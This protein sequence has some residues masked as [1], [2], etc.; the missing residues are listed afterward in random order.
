MGDLTRRRPLI[1]APLLVGAGLTVG[2][3]VTRSLLVF[4]ILSF[5]VGMFSIASNSLI[6]LAADLAPPERR[7]SAISI[8]FS[9]NLLGIL[10]ARVVAG[11]VA[12][13][14]TWRVVY[15]AAVGAQVACLVAMW[16]VLPDY[17]GS[18]DKDLT[19]FKILS[20]MARLAV[21][22]PTVI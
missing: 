2:L 16:A 4:E 22:E 19:Y 17:P 13:Y 9:G 18:K 7:A 12:Q 1:L 6:P 5:F 10:L 11:V 21:R 14:V 15:Y 3:A 20:S 8:A